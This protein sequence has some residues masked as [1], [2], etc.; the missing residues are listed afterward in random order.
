MTSADARVAVGKITRVHG[1][2]GEVAVLVLSEVE[3][4]FDPG[5]EVQL[6]D[7]RSLVVEESRP[8]RGRILV[9]FRGVSDRDLAERLVQQFLFVPESAS[10]RLPEGSWWDHQLE[11]CEVNVES[12]RSLGTLREVIHGGQR[13]LDRRERSGRGDAGAGAEGR[14]DLRRRRFQARDGA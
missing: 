2:R 13:R 12:G 5:A 9:W 6:E 4:R 11:G 1:V 3:G 7:G 8:H 10:P 14:R